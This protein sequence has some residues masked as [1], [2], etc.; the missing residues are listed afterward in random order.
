MLR[1]K[2]N[3]LFPFFSDKPKVKLC[4][5]NQNMINLVAYANSNT[6]KQNNKGLHTRFDANLSDVD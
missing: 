3:F 1:C 5:D 2:I 4:N 6:I